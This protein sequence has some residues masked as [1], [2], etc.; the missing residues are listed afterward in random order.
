MKKTTHVLVVLFMFVALI[1]AAGCSSG[2]GDNG[3]A[4]GSNSVVVAQSAAPLSVCPNNGIQVDAGID[5]N[6]NGILDASEITSTQYV[7]NGTDGADGTNGTNGSNGSN[8]SDG[9]CAGVTLTTESSGAN[10][11]NGGT[12][13]SVGPDADCD[14]VAESTTSSAYIC[15]GEDMTAGAA[16]EQCLICHG[17][18][19]VAAIKGVHELYTEASDTSPLTVIGGLVDVSQQNASQLAGLRMTGSIDLVSIASGTVTANFT[20]KD[21]ANHGVIG[22]TSS[23][24]RGTI[25]QLVESGTNSFPSYWM[26]YEVTSTSRPTDE[27]SGTFTDNGNGTYTYVFSK[28]I[29]SVPGV[30]YNANATHRLAIRMYGT[31][32]GGS[33]NDPADLS[34]DFVPSAVFPGSPTQR[35]IVAEGACDGCHYQLGV[36]TPHGGR[37]D[38]KYCVMC[39]T[40]QRAIGRLVSAPSSTGLLSYVTPTTASYS[41]YAV[42]GQVDLGTDPTATN[43]GSYGAFATGEFVSLIHKIHKGNKLTLQGYNFAGVLFNEV[44]FPQ[45]VRKCTTCHS[46]AQ[47]SR[48]LTN[49]NRKA[50]GACHDNRSWATSVPTSFVA[51]SNFDYADDSACSL[52]HTPTDIANIHIAIAEPDPNNSILVTALTG[53]ST[54]SNANTNAAC[55]VASN[56]TPPTGAKVVTYNVVS[57]G[58]TSVSGAQRPT[59]TFS[60]SLDG[61]PTSFNTYTTGAQLF[62]NFVG[63]PSVYFAWAVPQDG[64]TSPADFNASASGYI[65]NIWNGTATGTGAGTLDSS[66]TPTYSITLTGVKVA[67]NATLLTGGVGY[68]YSLSSTPPLTQTSG[69]TLS[70]PNV[71]TACTFSQTASSTGVGVGGL[72]VPAPD[73]AKVG[74]GYTGRRNAVDTD[75][76]NKCH[77]HLGANPSFHAGQR[78]DAPTCSFCHNPNRTSSGW[79]ANAS[80]F[81]HAI[82]AA[83]KRTVEFN[84]HAI[85]ATENFSEITYPNVLNNCEA[86][87]VSGYYDFS[88]SA[89]TSN[90]NALMG[91]LLFSTVATGTLASSSTSS[92]AFSPYVMLDNNYGSGFS[93]SASTGAGTAAAGTTLVSSPIAAACSSCHDS[94]TAQ[95]HMKANGGVLYRPRSEAIK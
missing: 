44:T 20:V 66:A 52:C 37:D 10:C 5:T 95:D 82:H 89:Y 81:I 74:T 85:S 61:T 11:A 71:A 42:S 15:N 57:V 40:Y 47:G 26:S 6:S 92:Y 79:S 91:N 7:C 13:V 33:I 49:P 3:A 65:K 43:G 55:V 90:D 69:Y 51:H 34:V 93:F 4:A 54:G 70:D 87:H 56:D 64:I 2:G 68:T 45:D 1:A 59:I 72:I 67:S 38:P 63:S 62:N 88:A 75:K 60:I 27:N 78:N 84:W 17:P 22:F 21:S 94:S 41:T 76:C 53:T 12:K 46:G 39:H 8:G 23:S 19:A 25:A 48:H 28:N 9:A 77:G 14:G 36:T 18:G 30:T 29:G 80:T 24:F 50:C 16:N 86:C 83:S 32:A 35:D 58:T 31:V 73:K